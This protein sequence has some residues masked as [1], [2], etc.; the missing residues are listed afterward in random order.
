[1]FLLILY[2]AVSVNITFHN[3]ITVQHQTVDGHS[4]RLVEHLET[5]A[6]R[7]LMLDLKSPDVQKSILTNLYFSYCGLKLKV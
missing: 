7:E 5:R 1:M 4:E 3:A 6:K 2:I